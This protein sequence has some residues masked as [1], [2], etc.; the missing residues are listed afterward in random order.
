MM[1]NHGKNQSTQED[2]TGDALREKDSDKRSELF[3]YLV[4][5]L[6]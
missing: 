1:R 6:F 5:V 3:L 4:A 2:S